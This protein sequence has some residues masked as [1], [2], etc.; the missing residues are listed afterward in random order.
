M[1]KRLAV[2][3]LLFAI[4]LTAEAKD[5]RQ[6]LG[7]GIKSNTSIGIPSLGIPMVAAV[8]YPSNNVGITGGFGIDTDKDNSKMVLSAGVRRMLFFEQQMNFYFGGQVSMVND[9]TNGEKE[10]GW[11]LSAVF[12]AEF[13]F[14]G[15]ENLAW[16]FEGGVGVLSMEEVRFTTI[17]DHPFRAGIIFYF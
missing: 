4:P 2:L 7:V 5:L 16:T 12:G 11:E 17:A 6:R 9:E 8:Y 3:T 10:S 15:L 1:L 13:F 14:Q